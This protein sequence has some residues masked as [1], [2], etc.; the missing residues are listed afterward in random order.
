MLLPIK[1]PAIKN[2]TWTKSLSKKQ[3]QN[4]RLSVEKENCGNSTV[5]A[6][7]D[8]VKLQKQAKKSKDPPRKAKKEKNQF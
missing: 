8:V 2:V 5:D 6:E 4:K 1:K 3:R 7:A